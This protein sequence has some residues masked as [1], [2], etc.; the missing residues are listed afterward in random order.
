MELLFTR[1]FA[2]REL[3]LSVLP[4]L[5]FLPGIDFLPVVG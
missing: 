2:E 3:M 4:D 5:G 1:V